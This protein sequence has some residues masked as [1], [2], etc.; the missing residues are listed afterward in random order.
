M[1][2]RKQNR[3]QIYRSLCLGLLFLMMFSLS[4]MTVSA[5]NGE[6][7]LTLQCMVE[8]N[9]HV[10]AIENDVFAVVKIAEITME[11][12]GNQY[13][14]RYRTLE[15]Y[16]QEVPGWEG[17]SSSQMRDVAK[18][19]SDMVG[20]EDYLATAKT[21]SKGTAVFSALD[22]GI[23][24][25]VRTEAANAEDAFEPFCVS[26][27]QKINGELIKNVVSFP[28]FVRQSSL[29]PPPDLPE[30]PTEKL[31]KKDWTDRYLPQ[32]GQRL[33]LVFLL[34]AIGMLCIVAGRSLAR[35][36]NAG[37]KKS[38]KKQA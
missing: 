15:P 22:E 1:K 11:Q 38:M 13:V 27:P 6:C 20:S 33:I 8:D 4:S 12:I 31:D 5:D 17:I 14:L 25:V 18:K 32:T 28:K 19:L 3:K 35:S 10:A 29:V 23:Y 36:G 24:L 30:L 2:N 16:R 26:V 34:L 21:D 7:S 37:E 9:G